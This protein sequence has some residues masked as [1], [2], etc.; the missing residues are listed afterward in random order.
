MEILKVFVANDAEGKIFI[1][2]AICYEEKLWLVPEWS[3]S[4]DGKYQS[5]TRIIRFD[6]LPHEKAGPGYPA[7]YILNNPLPRALLDCRSRPPKDPLYEVVEY[8]DIRILILPDA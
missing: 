8:P 7:E 1:C 6:N 3:G 4:K 5:P 2:D